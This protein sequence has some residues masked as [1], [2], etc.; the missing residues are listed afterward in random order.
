MTLPT[1]LVGT[2][3]FCFINGKLEDVHNVAASQSSLRDSNL[4]AAV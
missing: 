2:L 3:R 4:D 1:K